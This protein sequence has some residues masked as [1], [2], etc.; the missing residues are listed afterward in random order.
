MTNRSYQSWAGYPVVEHEARKMNWQTDSLPLEGSDGKSFLPYGNGRSYG[1]VCLNDGGIVVDCRGLNHF[2][3]F[4]S[5]N[6][7]LRCEAGV[8]LQEILHFTVPKGWFLSVTPGTQFVT[9]GGAIA[10]DV[11]GK[12]HHKAGTF[13]QHVNCFELLRSDGSRR[14]CSAEE[15]AEWYQATIGG[16]GLTG[17][18]TWAEIRLRPV[19]SALIDQEVIRYSNLA[20][21]F[22]IAKASDQDY[23]H[24]VAWIDCLAQGDQLGRGLFIRGNYSDTVQNRAVRQPKLNLTVPLEPPFTLINSMT[25]KM[26]NTVYYN[27]QRKDQIKSQVHYKPFFYPLDAIYQWNRIYGSKGFFQYQCALPVEHMEDAMGEILQRISKAGLGSF[28]TVLKLFGDKP[29][30]GLLSF[31][32]PGATLALDFPNYGQKTLDLL[33]QLDE[34]TRSVGGR[35]N[36]SKD[37]RMSSEDFQH[38]FTNWRKMEDYIDPR[39]SSSF[40]RRVTAES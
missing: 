1:D 4:D 28:L 32:M 12:N 11:H 37:A 10:N 25:L 9:V 38:H 21:F 16:L 36:P 27:K 15:N 30:P 29:S 34:V 7:I 20:E 33:N 26:F 18:I 6:G 35:V 13:G 22:E 17:V 19:K 8:T 31:P 2:I 14:L 23:E 39:I 24:T 5:E 3:E 40:W